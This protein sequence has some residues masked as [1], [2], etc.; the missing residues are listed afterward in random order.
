MNNRFP[1]I[2]YIMGMG[3]SGSTILEVLLINS[4]GIMGVGEITHVVRD[5]FINDVVCSCGKRASKCDFWSK[6]RASVN[7]EQKELSSLAELFHSVEWHSRFLLVFFNL[8]SKATIEKYKD[9]NRQLFVAAKVVSGKSLIVDSSKYAARGLV[10]ARSFP[11]KVKIICLTRSP[12]GLISSFRK[13]DAGEQKPKSL[14]STVVYYV[15]V[16][17][18]LRAVKWRLG[19]KVLGVRYEELIKN[20]HET[21]KKIEKWAGID[22]SETKKKLDMDELLEVGHIV[23]GNRLRTKGRVRFR[24]GPGP[25]MVKSSGVRIAVFFLELYRRLLGF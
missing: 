20:P 19:S 24:P 10:L 18:C 2:F 16:M 22:L 4:S 8:V 1:E 17:F 15:Y 23:T 21:L 11:G 12:V 3:R 9:V 6:V 5:G 14:F 7:W 13:T 25:E